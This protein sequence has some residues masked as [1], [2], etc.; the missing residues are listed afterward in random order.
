MKEG[1]DSDSCVKVGSGPHGEDQLERLLLEVY[2]VELH[3]GQSHSRCVLA[4]LL[5]ILALP[6]V[7]REDAFIGLEVFQHGGNVPFVIALSKK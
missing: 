6:V 1:L 5:P 2:L 7:M 3:D 4:H